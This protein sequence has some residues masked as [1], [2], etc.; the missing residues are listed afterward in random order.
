MNSNQLIGVGLKT[1]HYKQILEDKPS[2]GW[3]EVHSENFF[4]E[5]GNALNKICCIS[6]SY[7]ISLHGIGLSLGAADG[8]QE[9][10]LLRL[11]KLIDRINPCFVSEHLS[12]GHVAG[13]YIPDLLPIPYTSESLNI[14]CRN[15]DI[16]Q[17]FLGREIFIENPS[18]Y[19]E[20][21]ISQQEE[22]EFLVELCKRSGAKILFDI[23][24]LFVS[25][26]NH[27][28]DPIKYIDY[29]PKYSVKEIHLAGHM[30]KTLSSNQELRIDTHND[31]VCQEVWELYAYAIKRFGPV[32]TLLEWDADIPSLD[33]LIKEASKAL[34]YL[35]PE[36][37][38]SYV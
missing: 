23:N 24:N 10:H 29:I 27:G 25:A 9:E 12:W 13:V 34:K 3:F 26:S 21:K 8:I 6:E 15:V 19:I 17:N 1:P 32:P 35:S 22:S 20:Y 30:V 7:P 37:K 33:I 38:S 16:T 11:K 5:G 18:S 28:W 2:I 14:F 36:A 4:F 31:Y